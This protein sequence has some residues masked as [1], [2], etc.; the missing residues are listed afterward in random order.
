[1]TPEEITTWAQKD[2]EIRGEAESE[3]LKVQKGGKL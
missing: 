1:M 2:A 3:L